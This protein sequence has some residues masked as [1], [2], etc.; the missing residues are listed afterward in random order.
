MTAKVAATEIGGK[1]LMAATWT[2]AGKVRRAFK[3]GRPRR[4]DLVLTPTRA[5]LE[6]SLVL[7]AIQ[8]AMR[9]VDLSEDDIKAALVFMSDAGFYVARI[10]P[11][12]ELPITLKEIKQLEGDW[13]PL[14]LVLC[15][16]DRE[17]GKTATWD[18][19]WLVD[20]A[21][22]NALRAAAIALTKE[23]YGKHALN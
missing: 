18:L 5:L 20:M 23:K 14:G 11:V 16:L 13:R 17:A 22:K 21:S 3:A 9:A 19:A 12:S 8:E 6:G 15:Q 10:R 4:E 2:K 1:N 7:N